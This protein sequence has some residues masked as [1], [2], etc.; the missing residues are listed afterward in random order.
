[1]EGTCSNKSTPPASHRAI[2]AKL[3]ILLEALSPSLPLYSKALA[4]Q[5]GTS[6]RTLQAASLSVNG[7]RLHRHLRLKRLSRV[8]CQLLAGGQSVKA[9][10]LANGFLHLGDFSRVYTQAFGELPSLTRSGRCAEAT[11]GVP[12]GFL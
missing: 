2:I 4:A 3:D 7:T 5:I 1:M 6:V 12:G 9:A 10:A 8:R 11:S